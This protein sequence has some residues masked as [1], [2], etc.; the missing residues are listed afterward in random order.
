MKKHLNQITINQIKLKSRPFEIWDTRCPNFLIRVQPSGS[1]SYVV[2]YRRGKRITISKVHLMTPTQARD[3]ALELL[4]M[5]AAGA[6]DDQIQR[7]ARPSA[8]LTFEGFIDGAYGEWMTGE[9]KSGAATVQRLKATFYRDF[10]LTRLENI[11]VLGVERWRRDHGIGRI[12]ACSSA[13]RENICRIAGF[14]HERRRLS[15]DLAFAGGRRRCAVHEKCA[16]KCT[17]GPYRGGLY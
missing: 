6:T 3:M 12:G 9:R 7:A 1:K 14:R 16:V 4:G 15:H 13:W 11:S 17:T 5:S 2:Q 8:G 10:R